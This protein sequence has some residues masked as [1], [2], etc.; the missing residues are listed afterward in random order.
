MFK[1]I[2]FLFLA[3]YSL[4]V[5]AFE[6]TYWANFEGEPVLDR[7]S[8]ISDAL[9][10][11]AVVLFGS[12]ELT[13]DVETMP[14]KFIP[15]QLGI[16]TLGYG[17]AHFQSLGIFGLLNATKESLNHKSKVVVLISPGWFTEGGM[18]SQAFLEHMQPELL[19]KAYSD[20]KARAVFQGYIG[21]H[22]NEFESPNEYIKAFL[23]QSKIKAIKRFSMMKYQ[24]SVND[25]Y[26]KKV[27]LLNMNEKSVEKIF[28]INWSS[29]EN[30]AKN[31]ELSKMTNNKL[32]VRDDYYTKYLK[33]NYPYGG[34]SYFK[35]D[36]TV[37]PEYSHLK[38]LIDLLKSKNTRALFVM[39]CVNPYVYKD[40][41]KAKVI[42]LRVRK[43]VIDS[44][45]KFYDLS[46]FEYQPGILRD[47]MHLGELGF[48]KIDKEILEY[49]LEK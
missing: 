15:R 49:Y 23:P 37:S 8:R 4:W 26:L 18:P 40:S 5:F 25:I 41:S 31:I 30:N 38:E 36:V 13:G 47:T 17:H 46:D 42:S 29:M 20:P 11:K 10:G 19:V 27:G 33:D 24:E 21:K 34:A 12:S 44:G 35:E 48:L 32:Y 43:M 45:M 16:P 2:L 9:D 22:V 6:S 1:K 28:S 3:T 7:L 14:Y 39:Q